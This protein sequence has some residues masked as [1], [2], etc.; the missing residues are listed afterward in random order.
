VQLAGQ[1]AIVTGGAK[2]I[3]LEIGRALAREGAAL[4]IAD[5]DGDRAPQAARA[6]DGRALAV[7]TDV[8]SSASVRAMVTAAREAFGRIDILVNNAGCTTRRLVED[9]PEEEWRQVLEVN[10]TGPFLCAQAVLGPMK[11]RRYGRIVS[12]A[13]VAGKR[14][15]HVAGAHY[16]ASKAGLLGF[17][18]HLAYEAAPHGITVNAI[19]P[20][21]TLTPLLRSLY[22]PADLAERAR[23]IPLGRLATPEDV[24]GVVLFLVSPAAAFLTGQ[25]IDVD[26]GNLLGWTD[27]ETYL[28]K[29]RR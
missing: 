21:G 5:H 28:R 9:M 2:G 14:I 29:M 22:T 24:A 10:L 13:S 12:L 18:R 17:T 1:V 19:C 20:A 26:G 15:A 6:L 25:A 27:T 3:G 16:T 8:T 4:G 11:E 23:E 7:E